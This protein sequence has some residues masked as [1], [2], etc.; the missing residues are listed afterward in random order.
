MNT[1]GAIFAL[2]MTPS[3]NEEEAGEQ[4]TEEAKGRTRARLEIMER[5][6]LMC[7]ATDEDISAR[8]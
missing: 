7:I 8:T 5:E 1:F 3:D 2:P 6:V 4:T